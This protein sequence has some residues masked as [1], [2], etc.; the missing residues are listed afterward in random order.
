MND[1][2]QLETAIKNNVNVRDR[3]G[4]SRFYLFTPSKDNNYRIN[5]IY[6]YGTNNFL[7][8]RVADKSLEKITLMQMRELNCLGCENFKYCPLACPLL[9]FTKIDDKD[10]SPKCYHYDLINYIKEKLNGK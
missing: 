4:C 6:E 8:E 7:E 2:A 5:C 9:Y 3:G 10:K 1:V